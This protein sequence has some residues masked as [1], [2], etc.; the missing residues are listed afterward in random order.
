LAVPVIASGVSRRA[1]MSVGM[2]EKP[3]MTAAETTTC[4]SSD[5]A[6]WSSSW[7]VS[8]TDETVLAAQF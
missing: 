6:A 3:T 4:P 2:I 7:S 8:A 5:P 1:A